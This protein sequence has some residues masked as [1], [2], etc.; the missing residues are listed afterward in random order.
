MCSTHSMAL[1]PLVFLS[2]WGCLLAVLIGCGKGDP[3]L[4]P[5]DG[6][7]TF[8]GKPLTTGTVIF[9]P[10]TSKGNESKE[11]PRGIIDSEGRYRLTTHIID[12]AP[13]GWYKVT[14]SAAE[15][16]DPKNQYFT[17]WLIPEKS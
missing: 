4:I 12:G 15:Q 7:V 14:V 8:G 6:K 13:P 2:A 5:V 1:R 3:K 9:V 16:L 11:E 17:K 10:D